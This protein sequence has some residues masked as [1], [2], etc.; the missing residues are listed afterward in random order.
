MNESINELAPVLPTHSALRTSQEVRQDRWHLSEFLTY[1]CL[2]FMASGYGGYL[3]H[4]MVRE[5]CAAWNVN[6]N[7]IRRHL[8]KCA[9]HGWIMRHAEGFKWPSEE[10]A[11]E[12]LAGHSR[13]RLG[14]YSELIDGVVLMSFFGRKVT[15]FREYMLVNGDI[16]KYGRLQSQ[17]LRTL[18]DI[19]TKIGQGR[20]LG[21]TMQEV[22]D[23][24]AHFSREVVI[25]GAGISSD[26][27]NA[28]SQT[29]IR[30]VK[31]N[32][33]SK[34][35]DKSTQS[36]SSRL[37]DRSNA[38]CLYQFESPRGVT[39]DGEALHTIQVGNVTK[40]WSSNSISPQDI[41]FGTSVNASNP[42]LSNLVETHVTECNVSMSTLS[43][44]VGCS[45]STVSRRL[46]RFEGDLVT[47]KN[48]MV[49]GPYSVGLTRDFNNYS[50][51]DLPIRGRF[52]AV[53]MSWA[54][55]KK[56]AESGASVQ[57]SNVDGS[58]QDLG[59]VRVLTVL[60]LQN[61]YFTFREVSKDVLSG[62]GGGKISLTENHPKKALPLL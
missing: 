13:Q 10:I 29:E 3:S 28:N 53:R 42:D 6:Y 60:V 15:R 40:I 58:V 30:A 20:R 33:K 51:C 49:V 48:F 25:E 14:Q 2:R 47:Q 26:I 44:H 52:R 7:T 23:R 62:I 21:I 43:K 16:T 9:N 5:I 46:K 12:A 17:M 27:R 38:R 31:R 55:L 4:A 34:I 59:R 1:L 19:R 11:H 57:L 24:T 37:S 41:Q 54:Q 18:K 32:N 35:F 22:E 36:V 45:M 61:R 50:Q 56:F 39:A 8:S